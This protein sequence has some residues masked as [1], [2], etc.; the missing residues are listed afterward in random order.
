MK[1]SFR[2]LT[3]AA[4]LCAGLA[5]TAVAAERAG[6]QAEHAH[7]HKGGPNGGRLLETEPHAEFFVEK[8]RS[9]TIRFFSDDLK[10]VAVGEQTVTVLADAKEGKIKVEFDKSGDA[11]KSKS[12]LPAG[13]GYNLV[14]QVRA[15]SD[16]K[17]QNFRFKLDLATCNECK[18]PE[19]ACI[20]EH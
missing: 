20:C 1:N 10:P 9:V 3:L 8:D 13:D 19:Y 4:S 14:V 11:L 15:K 2:I 6:D 17:P 16:A 5:F 7:K 18:R 12:P